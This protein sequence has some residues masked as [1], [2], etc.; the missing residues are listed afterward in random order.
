MSTILAIETSTELASAALLHQGELI[1]RESAGAQTHSDSILPMIQQLLA[2]AGIP[3]SRCDALAFGV[4]P[5]SFTGVR[6]ACGVVQGLAFGIDRPVVPVVTLEAAAQACRAAHPDVVEVLPILDARMGEV[7]WAR[8][9]AGDDGGWDMLAEP[10]L[11]AAGQVGT[12]GKPVAC[13]NGLAVYA[14]HFT[15]DFCAGEFAAAYPQF[16]P[17]ARHVASLGLF[18]F[19]QGRALPAQE[20]QPLY[21]RNKVALTTAEREQRDALKGAA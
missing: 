7:Y 20:A 8:Y 18:H 13:G 4:G 14:A 3:L 16:M 11:S 6:T 21:L 1:S 9:R 12:A 19:A 2:E 15:P 10:A 5:G 17:H